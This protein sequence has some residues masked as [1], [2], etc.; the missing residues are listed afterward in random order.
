MPSTP[1]FHILSVPT[2][3]RPIAALPGLLIAAL[4]YA[5][6]RRLARESP[7][8]L[9]IIDGGVIYANIRKEIED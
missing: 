6:A 2:R 3:V 9:P 4:I 7:A 1:H 8:P 5:L